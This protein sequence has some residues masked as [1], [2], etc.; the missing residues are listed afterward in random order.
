MATSSTT[1]RRIPRLRIRCIV[2]SWSRS[3]GLPAG[4]EPGDPSNPPFG[5]RSGDSMD[6]GRF[7]ALKQPRTDQLGGPLQPTV[8]VG[9]RVGGGERCRGERGGH[10]PGRGVAVQRGALTGITAR[11]ADDF[12]HALR[13]ALLAVARARGPADRT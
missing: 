6:P 5:G 2:V 3:S 13:W 12:L 9:W 10:A 1:T 8:V 7:L 4:R 11:S